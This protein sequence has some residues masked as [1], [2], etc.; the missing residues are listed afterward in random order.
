MSPQQKIILAFYGLK[1]KM[2]LI[3]LLGDDIIAKAKSV[4]SHLTK[5]YTP[6]LYID[7]LFNKKTITQEQT[8]I[9]SNRHNLFIKDYDKRFLTDDGSNTLALDTLWR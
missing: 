7:V 2:Y 6:E 8:K 3:H 1:S 5:A 9:R 4:L